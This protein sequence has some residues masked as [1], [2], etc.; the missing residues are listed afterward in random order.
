RFPMGSPAWAEHV[1]QGLISPD[2]FFSLPVHPTQLYEIIMWIIM[3]FI[4]ITI[5]NRKP[6]KGT[7][8]LSFFAL[9]FLMRFIEDFVRADYNK[10]LW[11]FDLMQLLALFVIPLSLLGILLL[12]RDKVLSLFFRK[13]NKA[14]NVSTQN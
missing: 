2:P 3:A 6:R 13:K 11:S 1:H 5:R 10:I 7:I 4:L 8:I 14:M 12:Y 9:Y